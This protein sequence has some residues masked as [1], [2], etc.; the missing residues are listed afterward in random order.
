M[1]IFTAIVALMLVS[2]TS[3]YSQVGADVNDNGKNP[4]VQFIKD[5]GYLSKNPKNT[6]QLYGDSLKG[7]NEKKLTEHYL[8]SGV[9]GWEVQGHIEYLKRQFIKEKYNL[10]PQ[11]QT[12]QPQQSVPGK[13]KKGGAAVVNVAP[14]VN[15]GFEQTAPGVYN[16][17]NA[18]N[19]WTVE[20]R[21]ANSTCSFTNWTQGSPAFALVATP[22]TNWP[23][24][25]SPMGII[26]NSPL[27]GTVVAQLNDAQTGDYEMTR[28]SQTFPVTSSN[29]LFQF[30]YA[31]YWQ[32]GG[33]GHGCCQQPGINVR[34]YDC[35]GAPL[36]CVSLS[37]FPGSGCQSSGVTYTPHGSAAMWTNWQVKFV[38]FTPYI[39][40]CI[41]VEFMTTDCSLGGHYGTTLLD[42]MCG[43]QNIGTNLP[44]AQGGSIPGPVSFCAGSNVALIT[45]PVGYHSYQWISP[46]TG[47]VPAPQGTQAVLSVS[48]PVPGSVY[49]VNLV[50]ASGCQYVSTNTIVFSQVNVAGLGT[51]PSCPNG[52]SGSATVA[53]NGSG[54]GYTYTWVNS[55]NQVVGSQS[56]VSGLTPGIYSV[57]IGGLGVSCGTDDATVAI[58][59]QPP[60]TVSIFKP[61]CGSEAYLQSPQ[62]GTGHKWYYNNTPVSGT[63]GTLPNYTVSGNGLCNGC[64][65]WVS[66]TT[67]QGCKDSVRFTLVQGQPGN[68]VV[69]SAGIKLICETA[70]NGTAAISLSPANGA[71]SG[72]NTFSVASTGTTAPYNAFLGPTS[73]NVFTVGGLSPGTYTVIGFDGS[74][75]YNTTF[76]V[77]P[78]K[79]TW[80]VAPLSTT[81]CPGNNLPAGASVNSQSHPSQYSFS[82]SPTTWLGG[83]NGNV[84]N[85]IIS[86]SGIPNGGIVKTIYTVVAKPSVANC[87]TSHTLEVTA[88]N[89]PTPTISPINPLCNT[90]QPF[91][92]QA[93]P[94]GG[95][96]MNAVSTPTL[97]NGS[98]IITPTNAPFGAHTFTYAINV[99]TCVATQTATFEISQFLTSALTS[100]VAP[101]CVTNPAVN[102]MNIVQQTNGSWSGNGVQGNFFNPA[103]LSTGNYVVTYNTQSSP[104]PTVCPSSS[105]L[106]ISVTNTSVPNITPL[107]PFC[108]NAGIKT[109]TVSP[110]GGGWTGA[111]ITTAGVITPS[112]IIQSGQHS[113]TYTVT[114]GPCLNTA[115][116]F[117]H[118]DKFIPATISQQVKPLCFDSKP[119]NL[120]AIVA[121]TTGAWTGPNLSPPAIL[122]P[123]TNGMKGT[124]VYTYSTQSVPNGMCSDKQTIHITVNNPT[125]PTINSAGPYCSVD[126]TV[127]LTVDAPD[128]GSWTTGSYLSSKGVFDPAQAG[129]GNNP[130][131][132]VSGTPECFKETT[133]F[134]KIEAFVSAKLTTDKLPDLCNTGAM[135]NLMPYTQYA[136]GSWE[137]KGVLGN[138]F[139]PAAA[140]KGD[141][142]LT[143]TTASQPSGLCPDKATVA[144]SVFSLATP[145]IQKQGPFCSN[146]GEPVQL[147]ADVSGGVFGGAN[148]QA[149]NTS[150]LFLPASAPVGNNIINYTITS[151][152]CIA[153][154]QTTINVEKFVSADFHTIPEV[155]C[156]TQA[157]VNM[158]HY[159]VNPGGS[160]SGGGIIQGSSE[161]NPAKASP[162][163]NQIVYKT[164]SAPTGLCHDEKQVII[165]VVKLPAVT[166]MASS[167]ASCIPHEV[168]FTVPDNNDPDASVY[169]TPGDGSEQIETENGMAFHVFTTPGTY[170]VT[171][172]YRLEGCEAVYQLPGQVT[173]LAAPRA[174][175][176]VPDE[177]LISSPV[178]HIQNNTT[179]I[180]D[181]K[182]TWQIEGLVN[183]QGVHP[184]V[185]LPAA[186]KYEIT[187]IAENI[188]GC[189]DEVKKMIEVK[190]DFSIFIPTSFSPNFDNLNDEFKPVFSPYGLDLRTFEMEIFDRWGHQLFHSADVGNGWNGMVGNK[191]EPLKEGV[192]VYKIRYKDIEGNAYSK[193][194][195][196]SLL[197]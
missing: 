105:P 11:V 56:V 3:A 193:V 149:V 161:F 25:A 147:T 130:V 101:L 27:G 99:N 103:G 151:G 8:G 75:K 191:G 163:A 188:N 57:T 41:T 155:F 126:G 58:G 10:N 171:M 53:G 182:Y 60:S 114:D 120:M 96:F 17:A 143:Y 102:L 115:V 174:D 35:T 66:Y 15:E 55:S 74:C 184:V 137:G 116:T 12:I 70:S 167:H 30:A 32:D 76:Q 133:V 168:L 152:P 47:T 197:R 107:D 63:L 31:G 91:Q 135:V 4:K 83:G 86:P 48:N 118:V 142:L 38:D 46:I 18:V 129:I 140:G 110:G 28:I 64:N 104:N 128:G 154:A 9:P 159:A 176:T 90:F 156:S 180:G 33:S 170:T 186:G 117:Y 113:A 85:T 95:T 173:A 59:A 165:R 157:P 13:K 150:G 7:F 160:W 98:G 65:W 78:F 61:Y 6:H 5:Q 22:L 162:G 146:Q 175:F 196:V 141:H 34:M 50:T 14:C 39:G 43:G 179:P 44:P 36:A 109:M 94:G 123:S 97:I 132:Y 67:N 79:Y 82:W 106:S 87:P 178:V 84:Q 192:Y 148:T 71:P 189:S 183:P 2:A 164:V 127:Q 23:N 19:G 145:N 37:L 81:L 62:A 185:E 187:L 42:V 177:I 88:V 169:W 40:T 121:H 93:T 89:P 144:V 73:S 108:T 181:N 68:M 119:I 29:A 26:P 134:V 72:F 77:N 138:S 131:Q 24:T 139:D 21:S 190:N 166:P 111:N 158:N 195:H 136:S 69:P 52:S 1:R 49:T 20:S 80:S 125:K 122:T 153:F 54:A 51:S 112:L 16:T 45:A 100:T 124:F 92:I 172:T 194:G